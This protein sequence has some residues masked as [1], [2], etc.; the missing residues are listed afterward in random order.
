MVSPYFSWPHLW[1]PSSLW[2]WLLKAFHTERVFHPQTSFY[3]SSH[4]RCWRIRCK[5]P[6]RLGQQ[7]GPHSWF[8]VTLLSSD[9]LRYEMNSHSHAF[10]INLDEKSFLK[11]HQISRRKLCRAIHPCH[12]HFLYQIYWQT[13]WPCRWTSQPPQPPCAFPDRWRGHLQSRDWLGQTMQFPNESERPFVRQTVLQDPTITTGK[14]MEKE[15]KS[16]HWCHCHLS[17]AWCQ[18]H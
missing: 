12:E 6:Q 9:P 7:P 3:K 17:R 1:S 14:W 4:A 18:F 11:S 15:E 2:H 13:L 5:P 10:Q 16:T 8:D